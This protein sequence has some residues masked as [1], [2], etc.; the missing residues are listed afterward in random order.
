MSTNGH[1]WKCACYFCSDIVKKERLSCI[2]LSQVMKHGCTNLNLQVKTSL[3]GVETHV[4]AQ[5]QE[6]HKYV[7]CWE[8]DVETVLGLYW[9]HWQGLLG[10]WTDGQ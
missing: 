2:G 5:D 1:G 9:A 8:S 3:P 4:I 10:L 6:I 7:L